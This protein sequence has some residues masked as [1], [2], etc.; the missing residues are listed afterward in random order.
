MGINPTRWNRLINPSTVVKRLSL[1]AGYV[2]GET[3]SVYAIFVAHKMSPVSFHLVVNNRQLRAIYGRYQEIYNWDGLWFT[4][5]M[6]FA[7]F[8]IAWFS[9]RGIAEA[10]ASRNSAA[11][12]GAQRRFILETTLTEG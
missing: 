10:I 4:L 9:V 3:C 1:I 2:A 11:I 12:D 6:S 5:L 8:A 7:V